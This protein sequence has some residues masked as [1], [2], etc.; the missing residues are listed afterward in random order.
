M[1]ASMYLV[2][3]KSDGAWLDRWAQW[4]V[5]QRDAQAFHFRTDADLAVR[6]QGPGVCRVIE[7]APTPASLWS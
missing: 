1:V 7:F 3:R 4:S 5:W 2:R 6:Q